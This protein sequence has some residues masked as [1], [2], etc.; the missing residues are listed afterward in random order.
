[1]ILDDIFGMYDEDRLAAVLGWLAKEQR[2]II[3]STC[4]KR[5]MEILEKENIQYR[6]LLL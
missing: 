1:M 4:S 3:I 2:Q 6:G 5:E